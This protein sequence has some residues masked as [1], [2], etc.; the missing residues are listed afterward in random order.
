MLLGVLLNDLDLADP[1]V[2]VPSDLA[3]RQAQKWEPWM[4]RLS[5]MAVEM[6]LAESLHAPQHLSDFL[7]EP[8]PGYTQILEE[9]C[10]QLPFPACP[11]EG[12]EEPAGSSGQT[13]C[14]ETRKGVCP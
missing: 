1:G 12:F 8:D 9:H 11:T 10:E 6:V 7:Y 13:C 2:H 4:E 3:D 14:C 5:W